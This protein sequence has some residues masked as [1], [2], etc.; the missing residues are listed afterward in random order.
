VGR[1]LLQRALALAPIATLGLIVTEGNDTAR[2]M[3]EAVGFE[4]IASALVVQL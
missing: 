1:A 4:L 3:Y 2:R